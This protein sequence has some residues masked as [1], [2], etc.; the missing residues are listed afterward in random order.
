M[1]HISRSFLCVFLLLLSMDSFAQVNKWR[2]IYAAKKQDTVFGIA[3]K[4]G[5]SVDQLMEANPEMKIE[6]YQLKKGE[7]VFIPFVQ[8]EPVVPTTP[9]VVNVP[10]QKEADIAKRAIRI[11]VM[12]PLH[13]VDGDGKRM[14]EFYRGM[15][16]A[17]DDLKREGISTDIHAWNVPNDAD[18]RQ[19]LL[20]QNASKC[21]IIF[22]PLYSNQVKYLGD[23]CKINH[24]KLV[25]PFSIEGGDVAQNSQIF[26]VY[27]SVDQQNN[28]AIRAY[29]DRFSSYH[30]VF[31]DCNDTTS[32]KGIF[33]FGLRK[34]LDERK[35]PY[36]ITNLT[37]S[38]TYFAKSFST[39]KPNIVILNTSRSPE[40]NVALAK[41]DGLKTA[42][43][44]LSISLFGYTEWLMYTKVY[45]D[46]FFKYDTYIP[47]V[48]YYNPLS[49]QTQ[50]LELN[51]RR[52]FN[53]DMRVAIPRFALT[54]YDQT[55]FFCRGLH[56]YGKAFTGNQTEN[57]Y[58]PLQTPLHFEKVGNAG[59]QN[60]HFML[61]H[62]KPD[63]MIESISYSFTSQT[64]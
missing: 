21:D 50:Q 23:F 48:S 60:N 64:K 1:S 63:H 16:M 43:P 35:I 12:L 62:Y 27:Q 57:S 32:K 40:L 3:K 5:L 19:T 41:I 4:Y 54:G 14:V 34:Q 25:I 9:V 28:D 18:I 20:D 30:P 53:E 8:K 13:D 29:L 39:T 15:L 24:I 2:D 36:N 26:Q 10:A 52:W 6:G 49:P 31:I 45:L 7:T 61:I 58:I 37:S 47:T 42:R 59:M 46:Y 22:G 38:E 55:Q 51:Y 44:S 33:T 56:A 17:C 11:G